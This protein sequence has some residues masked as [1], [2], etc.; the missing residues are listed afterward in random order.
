MVRMTLWSY[1]TLTDV[2]RNGADRPRSFVAVT[3]TARNGMM[4]RRPCR[5]QQCSPVSR[6]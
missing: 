3:V 5:S 6:E 2:A 4:R 1:T